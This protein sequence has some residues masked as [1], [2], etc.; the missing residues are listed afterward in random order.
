MK[1]R[2]IKISIHSALYEDFDITVIDEGS[3]EIEVDEEVDPLLDEIIAGS[4]YI[5]VV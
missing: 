1:N 3:G 4:L 5:V 2:L